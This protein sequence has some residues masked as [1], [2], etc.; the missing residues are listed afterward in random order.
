MGKNKKSPPKTEPFQSSESLFLFIPFFFSPNVPSSYTFI[1]KMIHCRKW[2]VN[3]A[4]RHFEATAVSI[5]K[6]FSPECTRSTWSWKHLLSEE[7]LDP[8]LSD[9]K[10][11]SHMAR[12]GTLKSS[13][14][15]CNITIVLQ[16]S[17]G[18]KY[19]YHY[20][21]NYTNQSENFNHTFQRINAKK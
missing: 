18:E 3:A 11:V 19:I 21:P 9:F 14:M 2:S 4:S 13:E 12:K 15:K 10:V 20:A 6:I 8:L 17:S 7:G 1:S 16:M 5:D